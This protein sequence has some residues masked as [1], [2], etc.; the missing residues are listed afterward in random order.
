MKI[1]KSTLINCKKLSDK[2][3]EKLAKRLAKY[4]GF[5]LVKRIPTHDWR[6][7]SWRWDRTPWICLNFIGNNVFESQSELEYYWTWRQALTHLN[8]GI[9]GFVTYHG[10]EKSLA[11]PLFPK[12]TSLEEIDLV[13]TIKCY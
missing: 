9:T 10:I 12:N 2:Q 3:C 7:D 11:N 5:T 1:L 6:P 13:L 8:E 4:Y